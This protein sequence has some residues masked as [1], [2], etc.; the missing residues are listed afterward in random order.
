[1]ENVVKPLKDQKDTQRKIL[2]KQ[3]FP[4]A[5]SLFPTRGLTARS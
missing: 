4:G 3:K 2:F 5:L 1:M